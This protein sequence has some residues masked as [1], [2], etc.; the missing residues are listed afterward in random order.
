MVFCQT[1]R[2]SEEKSVWLMA[3]TLSGERARNCL[4]PCATPLAISF[5]DA[6]PCVGLKGVH[7]GLV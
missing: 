6:W 2:L 4:C 5:T 3:D 7:N 1:L